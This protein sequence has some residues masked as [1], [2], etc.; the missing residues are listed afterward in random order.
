MVILEKKGWVKMFSKFE[1][2]NF[3][4]Q[5]EIEELLD[6]DSKIVK[7]I[8]FIYTKETF[9]PYFLNISN[10]QQLK[11]SINTLGPYACIL[12]FILE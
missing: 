2:E 10:R 7:T 11:D 1:I 4:K 5:I 8:L 6:P 9:L 3:D 12:A